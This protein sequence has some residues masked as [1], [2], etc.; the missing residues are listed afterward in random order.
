[1]GDVPPEGPPGEKGENWMLKKVTDEFAEPDEGDAL[2]EQCVT[3]VTTDRT[4]AEIAAGS[5][6]WRSNRGGKKGGRAKKKAGVAP[7]PFRRRSWRRWSTRCRPGPTGCSNINMTATGCCSPTGGRRGDGVDPQWQ[8][9]E[10][11][12]PRRWSRRPRRCPRGCLIDGEAVA[13]GKNGKP[14]FGLLQATLK[15]G[16][17]DLAFYAFDLL[18]DQGEDITAL[19][20]IERKERLA[21]LLKAVPAPILYGDHV[22]AKGEALFDAICKEGGEG[23]IAKKAK[24]PYR[25]ARGQELA[26]GQVHPAPGI[27]HRRL[28]GERQEARL[29][30]APP[31]GAR[32]EE[33]D[34]CRQG[35]HRL[36]RAMIESLSETMAPL[37]IDK[38]PLDVPRAALRGSH[39]IEPKLVGE[40]AFTEFTSD[41][42][43]RHPSFIALREDKKA[44]QVVREVPEKAAA[45]AQKKGRAADRRE[46][47]RQDHQPRPRDL[48]R[49][50]ADQGR[51]R[52][53]LCRVSRRCWRRWASGR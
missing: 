35:R 17:A 12:V 46:L 43:L 2:V 36:Q 31:R 1:M 9:L 6:E 8:G 3:S 18:V 21:A 42:V 29:P 33:A 34:L 49:R 14:D 7:P 16:D 50:R 5:D 39:W 20:N 45:K 26:Q 25:G 24:A 11:Q 37:A 38:P 41:G 27:R 52:R 10:R 22:I 53:L 28:A 51:P 32:G 47:R 48:P 23:I 40:V 30:L 19:P 13:L 44:S 15:G 4:M